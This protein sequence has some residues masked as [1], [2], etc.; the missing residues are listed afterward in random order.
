MVFCAEYFYFYSLYV[1]LA[2]NA[3]FRIAR[4]V[5]INTKPP[6]PWAIVSTTIGAIPSNERPSEQRHIGKIPKI[7]V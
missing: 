7:T 1:Y 5:K 6:P 3:T 4:L 2:R